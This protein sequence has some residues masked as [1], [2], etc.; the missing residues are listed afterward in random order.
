LFEVGDAYKS[1]SL[2][3]KASHKKEPSKLVQFVYR[4]LLPKLLAA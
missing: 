3:G 2:R 1:N 4:N